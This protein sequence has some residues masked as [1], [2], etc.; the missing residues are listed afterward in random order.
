M[1]QYAPEESVNTDPATLKVLS[2]RVIFTPGRGESPVPSPFKS[3]VTSPQIDP[4]R[5][6]GWELEGA[7]VDGARTGSEVGEG[8]PGRSVGA[9]VGGDGTRN[10]PGVVAGVGT[11]A[12]A[13]VGSDAAALLGLGVTSLSTKL[14]PVELVPLPRLT[15]MMLSVGLPCVSDSSTYP[16]GGVWIT[17]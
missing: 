16:G 4:R 14:L 13:G 2:K 6:V 10:G 5:T 3:T 1:K 8:K 9:D 17:E 15:W 11:V 12:G 7:G